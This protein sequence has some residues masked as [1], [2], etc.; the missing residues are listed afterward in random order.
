M[1]QITSL[2]IEQVIIV[3]ST[4][5]ATK[6]AGDKAMKQRVDA[7]RRFLSQHYG[8]YTS[9][10]GVGGW[11]SG[12]KHKLI[13]EY[14]VKVTGFASKKDYTK[15]KTAMANQIIKWGHQ[16]GQ[17]SMGFEKEGD[18]FLY[19]TKSKVRAKIKGRRK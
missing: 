6:P 1:S 10:G 19:N 13:K 15:N 11:Y 18:L 16:W 4:Q 9:V 12:N 8:G 3:P 5:G 2:P 17:E 14:V 7:V